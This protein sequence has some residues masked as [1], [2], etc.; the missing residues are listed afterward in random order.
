MLKWRARFRR[1]AALFMGG[2]PIING[3]KTYPDTCNR[4]CGRLCVNG[5]ETYVGVPV[6]K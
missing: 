6:L 3:S 4:L 2:P 1:G 5:G